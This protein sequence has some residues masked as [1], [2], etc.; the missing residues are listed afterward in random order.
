VVQEPLDVCTDTHVAQRQQAMAT[1][2]RLH[3]R[4]SRHDYPRICRGSMPI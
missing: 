3:S 2:Y 4:G 1:I